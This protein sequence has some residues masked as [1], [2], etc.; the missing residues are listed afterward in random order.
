MNSETTL[1]SVRKVSGWSIVLGVV[2]FICGILAIAL[3][4]GTS[5]GIVI[6]LAW[7]ILFAGSAI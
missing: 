6:L 3:P 2:M 4:F 1:G 5:V 7:L